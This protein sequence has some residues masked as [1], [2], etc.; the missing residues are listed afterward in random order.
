MVECLVRGIADIRAPVPAIGVEGGRYELHQLAAVD[1]VAHDQEVGLDQEGCLLRH[2]LS[3]VI[4][5]PA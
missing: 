2:L 3:F 4:I 1:K 5:F